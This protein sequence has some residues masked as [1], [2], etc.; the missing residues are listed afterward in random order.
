MPRLRLTR[1]VG[2]LGTALMLWDVWRRLPPRQRRW[3][4]KQARTHGPRV[5]KQIMDAQR[6]RRR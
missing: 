1:R 4:V 2:P 3:V 5:A 6:R